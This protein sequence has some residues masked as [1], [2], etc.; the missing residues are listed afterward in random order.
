MV[1]GILLLGVFLQ[2]CDDAPAP[3]SARPTG[4]TQ[5]APAD[6]A[7][8]DRR[9]RVLLLSEVQTAAANVRD[10]FNVVVPDTG[11]VLRADQP[12][13]ELV[14]VFTHTGIEVPELGIEA[15]SSA[16]DLV[17]TGPKPTQVKLTEEW[18]DFPG[19]IRFLR[20]PDGG[21]VLNLIDIED[22]LV[23]VVSSELPAGFHPEAFR[24]QAIAARTYAWYARQ[25]TGLRREW[26]VWATEKSQVYGG[27]ERQRVVPRAAEAVRD[28]R[29]IVCTWSGP[30]GEKIFCTYF[31]SRCG[32]V[33]GPA[34]SPSGG[35][36]IQPLAGGVPCAHCQRPDAYRW[37]QDPRIS[38]LLIGERLA[39]RY[40]RFQ[41]L[42][43]VARVDVVE[44]EPD[45]RARRMAVSDTEGRTLG[46]DA[47]NFRLTVDPTGRVLQST[48]FTLTDERESVL[49]TE[50]RGMGHGMG[51][52]QYGADA[53]A[54]SGRD[55]AAILSHYYPG[56][57]L[58][59]AY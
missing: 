5:S 7:A 57:R 53:L 4:T 38:K 11:E 55:A 33:S 40:S 28:T 52:C 1:L 14:V 29:G 12:P 44:F 20:R 17:P 22:Y 23:G 35:P 34:S 37:P 16:L 47:E 32:G 41:E 18:K 58:T 13:A 3:M 15:D 26:D 45:G 10:R 51:M 59:R 50:G 9:I 30:Q 2:G 21:A 56:S 6:S 46:I 42:G 25:T 19:S 49:F 8:M 43:P 27:L 54:R 31:G 36:P 39:N 24:A 48:V